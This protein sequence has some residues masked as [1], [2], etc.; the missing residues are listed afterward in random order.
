MDF[1]DLKG[2]VETLLDRLGFKPGEIEY[3]AAPDTA[4]FGPRCAEVVVAGRA[5]RPRWARSTRRCAPAFGLP[6]VRVNAAELRIEPLVRPAWELDPL[7]PIS[8]YPPVVEDLAFVVDE[9]VTV[10]MVEAAIQ[11]AGGALL[12]DVE[13]FDL[14]RGEPLPPGQQV[15]RLPPDLSEPGEQPA[16]RRR[17]QAARPHHPPRRARHE[18]QAAGVSRNQLLMVIADC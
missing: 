17:G 9:S 18:R 13:L 8:A 1:Y 15:A 7:Q 6:A 3:R 16:R 5:G 11:A 4:S 2:V 12:T 10:R 14:Y